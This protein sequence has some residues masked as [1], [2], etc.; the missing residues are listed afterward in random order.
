MSAI[1]SNLVAGAVLVLAPVATA[2]P[3]AEAA[4]KAPA[5]ASAPVPSAEGPVQPVTLPEPSL[6]DI[7]NDPPPPEASKPRQTVTY[8][9]AQAQEGEPPFYTDEDMAKLRAR[10]GIEA[11][12]EQAPRQAVW[13]CLVA[14]QTCGTTFEINATSAYALRFR[15]GDV[16]VTDSVRRWNSGRA[17]YDAQLNLPVSSETIGKYKFTR[18]TLGP[19]GGVIASDSRDIWGD[20]G[21]AGRYFFNRKAWSPT[22][23]FSA[24]LTFKLL[25][26][27]QCDVGGEAVDCTVP[28]RSPLGAHLDVGFG[29]GG[30][31]AIV[32]GGQYDSPLARE[33]LPEQF[34]VASAG[35]FYV[36]FRGNILWGA[37]LVG[38]V[39]THALTQR[40]VEP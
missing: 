25:G 36:G 23:E 27:G 14:D 20:M 21:I 8:Q 28:E 16:T 34:R 3:A 12:P 30:W 9:I 7:P 22:L 26:E 29:I 39:A 13:R 37:P 35:T 31:G 4:T 40:R 15:Q 19:K 1:I 6:V 2:A 11:A 38:A 10:H 17:Q 24:A 32:V 33:D 5:P 18:F